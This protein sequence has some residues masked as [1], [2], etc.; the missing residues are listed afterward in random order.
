MK[1][2]SV[3]LN[4]FKNV[5]VK[6]I[7]KRDTI[8]SIILKITKQDI[9]IKDISIKNGIIIIKGNQGLKSEIFLKKNSIL[10]T[11]KKD[12]D[13]NIFDIK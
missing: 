10:K 5:A 8:C 1:E 6:E 9:D 13:A 2:I 11:I 7:K 4:K 3:F 12:V